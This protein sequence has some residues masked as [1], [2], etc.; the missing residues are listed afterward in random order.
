MRA[1][2]ILALG[3]VALLATPVMA[4]VGQLRDLS[5]EQASVAQAGVSRPGSLQVSLTADRADAT[6]NIGESVKLTVWSNEE[7]YITVLDIGPTGQV[8]QLFPNQY[9]ADNH[10]LANRSIEIAGNNSGAK[11]TVV[12]PVGAELI[13]VI[14][15]SK[16]MT[17]V[18]ELQLQG[19]GFFRTIEGGSRTLLR[20]L[21]VMGDQAAAQ[22]ETKVALTNFALRTTNNRAS[23]VP[24]LI[25]V[26]GQVAAPAPAPAIVLPVVVAS[27]PAPVTVSNLA[28]QPGTL[29]LGSAA[30]QPFALLLAA[31]RP[32]YRVG[33]KVTLAVTAAQ[34]CN[35]TVLDISTSGQVRTLFPS[36]ATPNNAV[37]AMQTVLVAGGPSP[38]ALP[39]AGPAGTEQILA[40]CSTEPTSGDAAANAQRTAGATAMASVAF[41]VQP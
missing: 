26:P 15:S 11:V 24:T 22:S 21:Q 40:V 39:I 34:A 20:D 23:V 16:P 18:S 12:G 14:A 36:Q 6:Y 27:A 31:D 17:V 35:L 19:R 3:T 38:V 32:A 29:S 2:K 10:V 33:E 9:Q 37:G 28:P 13:K 30:Q 41:T 25:V 7:A 5:V 1:F 4:Q 8:V